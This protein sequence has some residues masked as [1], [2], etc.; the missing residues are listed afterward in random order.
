MTINLFFVV[1]I[2]KK[3]L[4]SLEISKIFF[5]TGEIGPFVPFFF[6][7]L[8]KKKMAK[9]VVQVAIISA[10]KESKL[11]NAK[12]P[13]FDKELTLLLYRKNDFRIIMNPWNEAAFMPQVLKK[14][15]S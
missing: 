12:K 15:L 5:Q 10:N 9:A 14:V 2:E 1:L 6:A 13:F 3:K 11:I 7:C 4:L 8:S